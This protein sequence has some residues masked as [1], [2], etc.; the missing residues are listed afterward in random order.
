[1]SQIKKIVAR[2]ILDSRGCPTVEV[3]AFIDDQ[4]FARAA[5]PS[6]ASTGMREAHE[7]RDG[8]KSKFFG[9]GVTK[10]VNN[11]N[12][13][14][15]PAL[16][17]RDCRAQN[18]IDSILLELDGT[19][20]C[21]NLGSNAIVATSMAILKAASLAEEKS[22]FLHINPNAKTMPVPMV[23]ILNGGVHA[24]NLLDIQEFMI[25]PTGARNIRDAIRMGSEI[26]TSLKA[27]LMSKNLGASVGDEG[28]FAPNLKYDRDALEL[29]LQ[30]TEAAGYKPG[31]DVMLALDVAATELY[32]DGEYQFKGVGKSLKASQLVNYYQD[33]VRDYPIYSIEDGIA[34]ADYDGWQEMTKAL[35]DKVQIVGDDVFATNKEILS[36]CI[37]KNIANAVLIKPNQVGTISSTFDTINLAHSKK[38]ECVMSHRSG[39]TEDVTIA[40]LAV[41][42][43]CSQIK[44]GSVCRVDRTAKYNELLRISE[45]LGENAQYSQLKSFCEMAL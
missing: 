2:E 23:N 35:G 21:S 41:A 29:I 16:I 11:V 6:G 15:S 40:H 42:M 32:S 38:Y 18:E 31:A 26:F 44:T 30:A 24:D 28:G 37:D 20:T 27:I 1:M 7:L 19:K 14:I 12:A 10:A 22:L 45:E 43:G 34:E 9:K 17:G 13:I 3:D 39:E 5:A 8:D 36:Q 25:M 33:M 4:R